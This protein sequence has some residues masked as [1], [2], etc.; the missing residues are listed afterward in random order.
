M[1]NSLLPAHVNQQ[2]AWISTKT[3]SRPP[4]AE[5]F[6][7]YIRE[8]NQWREIKSS[9]TLGEINMVSEPGPVISSW[10]DYCQDQ[11]N[12]TNKKLT[13]IVSNIV[14]QKP[15]WY[16]RRS[17]KK[18]VVSILISTVIVH[19]I[20]ICITCAPHVV[21]RKWKSKTAEK[22]R[23]PM[24]DASQHERIRSVTIFDIHNCTMARLQL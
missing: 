10:N 14:L 2:P 24:C 18:S 11:T 19:S 8:L 17:Y 13:V 5:R 6:Q 12:Q 9:N 22:L 16:Q 3:T 20:F 15:L 4:L 7:Q 21:T 1:I 23:I